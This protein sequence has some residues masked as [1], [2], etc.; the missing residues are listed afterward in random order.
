MEFAKRLKE[1]RENANLS[2]K[3]LAEKVGLTAQAYNNYEKRGY[4][5][6]PELLVKLAIALN[7]TPNVL[8]DFKQ[9]DI[10]DLDYANTYHSN[11]VINRT[12]AKCWIVNENGD[13]EEE[14]KIPIN[15]FKKMCKFAR[16]NTEFIVEQQTNS[17][18]FIIFQS[19]LDNEVIHYVIEKQF[20]K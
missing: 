4:S 16:N 20:D 11:I 2:Q 12:F 18:R 15:K 6:T 10:S 1:F 9:Q 17:N 13:G 3:E 7:T 5:P 8:L 19:L 14:I